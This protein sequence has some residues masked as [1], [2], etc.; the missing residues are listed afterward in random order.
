MKGCDVAITNVPG[1]PIGL[2]AAGAAVEAIVPFAPKA[3]AAAN[4][5]L[6]TYNGVAYVG[7]NL[8]TRAVPDTDAFVTHIAGGFERVLALTGKDVEV[9]VGLHS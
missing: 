3:G 6:M 7:I 1:P 9:Q 5:G 8:D 4:F 2:Y